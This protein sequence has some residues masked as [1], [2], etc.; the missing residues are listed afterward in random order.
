MT[1]NL[2]GQTLPGEIERQEVDKYEVV[3]TGTKKKIN[4]THSYRY[5]EKN[6]VDLNLKKT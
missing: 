3:V 6:K 1:K 2:I 5:E 4:L